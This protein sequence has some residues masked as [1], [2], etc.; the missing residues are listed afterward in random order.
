M[1]SGTNNKYNGNEDLTLD[2]TR[3]EEDVIVKRVRGEEEDN[4]YSE[5]YEET[6]V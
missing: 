3:R 2:L 5:D 6:D 4:E 1:V